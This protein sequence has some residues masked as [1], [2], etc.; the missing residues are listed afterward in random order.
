M[1]TIMKSLFV[2]SL[3]LLPGALSSVQAQALKTVATFSIL[4]DWVANVGGDKIELVVLVGP[5]ADSHGYEPTP[6]DMLALAGA[7]IVFENGL[8]FEAWLGALYDASASRARRVVVTEGVDP[9]AAVESG[10]QN[11]EYDHEG[12]D[13][14]GHDHDHN[15]E[16]HSHEQHAH[17]HDHGEF[18]PHTWH[19][20]RN[21]VIAVE[22]IRDALAEADPANAASYSANAASYLEELEALDAF[23]SLEAS[24]LPEQRRKLVTNHHSLGYFARAY[25]F[26]VIGTLLPLSTDVGEAAAGDMSALI[27]A[28]R[29]AG[30]PAL[31]VE[32]VANSSLIERIA[33]EAGVTVAPSLYTDAL[34]AP[35]SAGDTYLNMFRHNLAVITAALS[36]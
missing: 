20:V 14:P 1:R 4:G 12:H 16:H 30:I 5:D 26:E 2:L 32:N 10:A 21:A 27:D 15:H 24:R 23:V 33:A 29:A 8:G 17:E 13:R 34:G 36:R 9:I 25:G 11:T 3:I 18:D 6:R 7:D 31:F 35:G 19:D 28:I 22:L